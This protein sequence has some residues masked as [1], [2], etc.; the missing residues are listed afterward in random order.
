[1]AE[2]WTFENLKE[3]DRQAEKRQTEKP[4]TDAPLIAVP[5]EYREQTNKIDE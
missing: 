4:I 2:I 3:C 1:M 5:K